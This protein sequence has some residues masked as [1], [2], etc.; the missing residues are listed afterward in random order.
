MITLNVSARRWSDAIAAARNQLLEAGRY[1]SYESDELRLASNA[2]RA[3]LRKLQIEVD[4]VV[5]E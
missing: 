5:D 2:V 3:A 4:V 1:A